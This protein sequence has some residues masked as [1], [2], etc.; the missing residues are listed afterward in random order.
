MAKISGAATVVIADIDAGR[1]QFA[2]D[3]K[4]AHRG[5][6]VPLKRGATIEEQL[7][8]AKETAAD[9]G[10]LTRESGSPVGEVD[11][12]FECTGVP[13][14]VQAAIYVRRSPLSLC[15]I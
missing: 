9:I 11:A 4:F 10:K 13:S 5:F 12:V 8:I 3:N 14:C 2:I 1:V 15:S 6:T 7:E